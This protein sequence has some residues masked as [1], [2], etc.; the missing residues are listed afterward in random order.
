MGDPRRVAVRALCSRPVFNIGAWPLEGGLGLRSKSFV[1]LAAVQ[2]LTAFNDNAYRWLIIP[3]GIAILGP[4]W[5]SSALSIGLAVFVAV[6][7]APQP[8]GL[9][10]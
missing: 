9:H 6:H 4:S 3:I 7:P 10:R 5:N 8:C 2:F 1:G